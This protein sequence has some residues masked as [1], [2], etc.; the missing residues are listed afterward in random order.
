MLR[1]AS[2]M[3]ILTDLNKKYCERGSAKVPI[4]HSLEF[5]DELDKKLCKLYRKKKTIKKK[6]NKKGQP[7]SL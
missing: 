2:L 3:N 5:I 1:I 7:N 4:E 6:K